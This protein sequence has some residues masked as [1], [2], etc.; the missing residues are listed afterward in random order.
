MISLS[1]MRHCRRPISCHRPM[2]TKPDIWADADQHSTRRTKKYAVSIQLDATIGFIVLAAFGA[3][4]G[5]APSASVLTDCPPPEDTQRDRGNRPLPM[6]VLSIFHTA[7]RCEILRITQGPGTLT[8]RAPFVFGGP[9]LV[10]A[11]TTQLAVGWAW[12]PCTYCW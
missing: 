4:P 12:L 2:C 9:V 3:C 11:D 10:P 7:R 8:R 5:L 6:L 1:L